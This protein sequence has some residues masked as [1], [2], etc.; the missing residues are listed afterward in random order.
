MSTTTT[1]TPDR[2]LTRAEAAA[3]LG[4]KPQTL[5][6]WKCC[7]R[8][9]LPVVLVG[10]L[11]RYRKSDLDAWIASRTERTTPSDA[12]DGWGAIVPQTPPR[13]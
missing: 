7:G 8:Y 13:Q 10:R 11:P 4:I 6:A 2:L 9:H 5:S 3:Y 1:A 12:G